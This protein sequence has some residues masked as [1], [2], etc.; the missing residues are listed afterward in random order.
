MGPTTAANQRRSLF[1]SERQREIVARTLQAGRVDVRELANEL[2]VTAETIRRDLSD[3]QNQR[4]VRRVHGG[5]VPWNTQGFEPLL[6]VRNDQQVAEKRRIARLAVQEVPDSGTIIIDSGSTLTPLAEYLPRDRDLQVVTNSLL[7]AQVLAQ[8]E[9]VD[10]VV[11]GG[12][13][14]KN[15]LAMVDS[16]TVAGVTQLRVDTLFISAD[17]MSVDDGLTTPYR[18]EAA[19]KRAMIAAAGRVVALVDFS[20]IGKTHLVRFAEWSDIDVLVTDGRADDTTVARL[21]AAGPTVL[22]A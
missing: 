4:L 20:K 3:L 2:E 11:L 16:E 1:Q 17:G 9:T 14:R 19:L 13:L 21:E 18:E 22:R 7:T 8:N 5:A 10:V 6:A 15:T 12:Q